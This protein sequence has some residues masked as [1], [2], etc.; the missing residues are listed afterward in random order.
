MS[1]KSVNALVTLAAVALS[2]AP[3]ACNG[4]DEGGNAPP[5]DMADTGEPPPEFTTSG[6]GT[7]TDT[8][9]GTTG[10]SDTAVDEGSSSGS[11]TGD[12]PL[13]CGELTCVG[14]GACVEGPD[15]AF[16]QCDPGYVLGDNTTECVIDRS[17]VT[18]RFLEERC[19]QIFNGEP[20]VSLFFALDFCAGTAVTPMWFEQLGLEFVVLENDTDI[21]DNVE[22]FQTVDNRPVESFVTL[23]IDMSESVADNK[24]LPTLVASLRDMVTTLEP[25][26]GEPPVAVSV[27]VFGRF[28][29]ELLPF[30]RD[31]TAVDTALASIQADPAAITAMV[32]GNGTSLYEAVEVGIKRTQ[33]IR[34]LRAAVTWDG[35]LSTGTVV[36]VTDGK[37]T[38]NGD[39]DGQLI[40]TTLNQVISIGISDEVDDEDLGE[41]GRDGSFLAPTPDDWE[42]A[43]ADV[44][45]RV[46]EYPDRSYLLS[47][48]SS[49][50][51]GQPEVTVSVDGPGIEVTQTTTCQFIA[52]AFGTD[53]GDVCDA[54]TFE[55]D[56]ADKQCGGL[57]ACG[58]CADDE[59]CNGSQCI[60]PVVIEAGGESCAAA[61]Q[62]CAAGDQ[63]CV[64]ATGGGP[65]TCE[66][67][68]AIG[69][70]CDPGCD[71]GVSWCLEG[72]DTCQPAFGLGVSC[73]TADQCESLNCQ[74]TNP[75][76]PFLLPTC[77][78]EALLFDRCD[79]NT[80]VCE[81]GGYCLGQACAPQKFNPQSCNASVECRSGLC[82]QPV[83]QNI[84]VGTS[85]CYWPWSDKMPT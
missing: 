77:Q 72:A 25:D 83:D 41:I 67:P 36:V 47:Y 85:M 75:D 61:D 16:C 50:T 4:D 5:I 68:A 14:N 26:A 84:C 15:G 79:Q 58:A 49:A 40:D 37:D 76:N 60:S 32:N 64:V 17:C 80:T 9:T 52:D 73:D 66:F 10:G 12:P 81:A 35:V 20:A 45:Q 51:E 8:G 23:V 43:F 1:M 42:A 82:T 74:P 70:A 34:D 28:V 56:C 24:E 39:L 69:E 55:N 27:Y 71:P 30:T 11:T 78:E 3:L 62:F 29:E 46:D 18:L 21:S 22:S 53:P 65:D 54:S 44:A 2:A 59:C 7:G 13:N 48:C 19:R 57:T 63:I 38:S 33:R 31:L 6:T